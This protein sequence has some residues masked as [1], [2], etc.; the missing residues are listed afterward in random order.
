MQRQFPR[1]VIRHGARVGLTLTCLAGCSLQDFD[2]LGNGTGELGTGGTSSAS[3]AGG[4][5]GTTALGGSAGTSP[6][7]SAGSGGGSSGS[8]GTGGTST[9]GGSG[10]TYTGTGGSSAGTGSE[11]E[12][13]AGALQNLFPAPGFENG[14]LGWV[15]FGDSAIVDAPGEGR[16]G[17]DC[18]SSIN[19]TYTYEGPSCVLDAIVQSERGYLVEAWVRSESGLEPV[20]LSVKTVCTETDRLTGS[21]PDSDRT[22]AST[23]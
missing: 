13:D 18:I 15:G 20:S 10:G 1:W 7:G 17:S 9:S 23:R 4:S 12:G 19:R 22:Q 6:G 14:H 3:G 11:P 21:R 5:S 16:D 2:A 8:A